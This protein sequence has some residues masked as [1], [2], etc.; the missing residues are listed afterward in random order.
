V[1]I[2]QTLKTAL[3]PSPS[4]VSNLE[5]RAR[6]AVAALTRAGETQVAATRA[7]HEAEKVGDLKAADVAAKKL[8]DAD[9][10]IVRLRVRQRAIASALTEAQ[11]AA[12]V[13]DATDR[14]SMFQADVAK[15]S[16]DC[17]AAQHSAVVSALDLSR[18]IGAYQKAA[19][20]ERAAR[21]GIS[22]CQGDYAGP[23]LG[24]RGLGVI[25]R[26]ALVKAGTLSTIQVSIPNSTAVS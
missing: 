17:E 13:E 22:K 14:L 25:E 8:A 10:D 26:A 16:R 18:H 2:T 19:A 9:E 5:S 1:T 6:E 4:A 23:S 3:G 21:D 24:S 12:A 11:D 7:L 20:A 15:A